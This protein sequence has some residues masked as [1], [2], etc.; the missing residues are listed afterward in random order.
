MEGTVSTTIVHVAQTFSANNRN[1]PRLD[2]DCKTC[3]TLQEQYRGYKNK[4]GAKKKQK[5]LSMIAVKKLKEIAI[6]HQ[7][8]AVAYLIICA[9]FFAMRSCE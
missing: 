1:D 2:S 8:E 6:L 5:A 9:V 7:D 4:N 3:F